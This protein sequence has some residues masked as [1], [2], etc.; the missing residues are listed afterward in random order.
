LEQLWQGLLD[1][2]GRASPFT[3]SY[4]NEA[5]PVSL[6]NGVFTIGFDPEFADKLELVNNSK[7]HAVLQTKLQELG[8]AQIQIKFVKT[9]RLP[10]AKADSVI[11]FTGGIQACIHASDDFGR[12]GWRQGTK[13]EPRTRESECGR[14]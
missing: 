12:R 4:L 14:I 9:D 8:C 6:A 10:R 3:R 1:A 2:V 13:S 5:F 11:R 7:T